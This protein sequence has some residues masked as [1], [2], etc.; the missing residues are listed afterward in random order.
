MRRNKY[1]AVRTADGFPSK[2]EAS[3]YGLLQLRERLGEISELKRQQ[4][5]VLLDGA[6]KERIT[7]RIDFAFTEN[8]KMAYAE[9]KGVE[10]RAF[11]L[12]LKMYKANPPAKLYI[13]KGNY[14]R[15]FI[16]EIIE[17]KT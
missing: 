17:P 5:I 16:S 11:K 8:G 4:K 7:W 2:L 10:D 15:P 13:Y 14:R 12:K 9:A 3:V 1:R 6:P